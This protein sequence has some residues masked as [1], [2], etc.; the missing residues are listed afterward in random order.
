MRRE[1]K[2]EEERRRINDE[3]GL[4]MFECCFMVMVGTC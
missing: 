4:Q 3:M 1:K 2:R